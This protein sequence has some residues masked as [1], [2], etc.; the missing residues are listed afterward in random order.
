MEH[1]YDAWFFLGGDLKSNKMKG[2]RALKDW[3][4]ETWTDERWRERHDQKAV[5]TDE[6]KAQRSEREYIFEE[7][8]KLFLLSSYLAPPPSLSRQSAC[9][10][11]RQAVQCTVYMIEERG[12]ERCCASPGGEGGE[13]E[14]DDS[15]EGVGI[16]KYIFPQRSTSSTFI[17]VLGKSCLYPLL[18]IFSH[19]KKKSTCYLRFVSIITMSLWPF[20]FWGL[21]EV[22]T[23]KRVLLPNSNKSPHQ[24]PPW[25]IWGI[26]LSKQTHCLELCF[27]KLFVI[28]SRYILCGLQWMYKCTNVLQIRIV[29]KW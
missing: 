27:L 3:K 13:G 2:Y 11:I 9:I 25:N 21:T 16:F 10:D 5:M 20:F 12:T 7:A 22:L 24:F 29:W 26:S 23:V 17:L 8:P 6:C 19:L 18:A 14:E 4:G 28:I 1:F 15:K